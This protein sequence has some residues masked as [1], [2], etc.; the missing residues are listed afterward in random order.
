MDT[1]YRSTLEES[2][3]LQPF[4]S[5]NLTGG[6]RKLDRY[7][8]ANGSTSDIWRGEMLSKEGT[9]QIVSVILMPAWKITDH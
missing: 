3:C 6:V 1:N 5:Q 7:Y 8:I 2:A 9:A 4:G